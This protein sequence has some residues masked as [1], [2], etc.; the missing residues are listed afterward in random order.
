VIDIIT[1][2]AVVIYS[3]CSILFRW[4]SKIPLAVAFFLLVVTGIAIALGGNSLA[5]HLGIAMFYFLA[6]GLLMLLIEHWRDDS[7]EN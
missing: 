1:L 5:D 3:T 2:V 6:A 4:E 7:C